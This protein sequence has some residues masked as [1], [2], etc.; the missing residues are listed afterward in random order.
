MSDSLT[1][2]FFWLISIIIVLSALGVVFLRNIFHSA[3]FLVI[4][5]LGVAGIYAL[6]EVGF[7]AAVQVLIYAGAIAIFII[8]AI[9]LVK[10]VD[11]GKSNLFNKYKYL[12]GIVC[13]VFIAVTSFFILSTELA[14]VMTAGLEDT[15]V[16]IGVEIMTDYV[17]PLEIIA[18]LLLVAFV[19]ANLIAKGVK[20]NK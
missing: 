1:P 2:V 16:L 6:L 11:I 19:G 4:S 15:I 17:I 8:F 12:A 13:M 7:L 14:S 18:I 10:Q 9:M 5:F 3:L 20:K